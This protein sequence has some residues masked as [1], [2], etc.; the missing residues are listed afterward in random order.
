VSDPILLPSGF[1]WTDSVTGRIWEVIGDGISLAWPPSPREVLASVLQAAVGDG[2]FVIDHPPELVTPTAAV[3]RPADP[4]QA[5]YTA[6]GA[7]GSA[8]AF[9]VDLI[10]HRNDVSEGLNRLER[11]REFVCAELPAG[12]RWLDFGGVGEIIVAD[13]TYLKGTL[14]LAVASPGGLDDFEIEE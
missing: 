5:P 11:F 9:E 10:V 13:K 2:V 6:S 4:Y 7:R 3:I 8:W 14:G 1:T 12:W